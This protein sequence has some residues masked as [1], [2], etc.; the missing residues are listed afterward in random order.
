MSGGLAAL[1]RRFP[2]WEF[3]HGVNGGWYAR[4]LKSSPPIVCYGRTQ[5]QLAA[6]VDEARRKRNIE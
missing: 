4:R 2:Y 1:E 5:K 6:E 3:W